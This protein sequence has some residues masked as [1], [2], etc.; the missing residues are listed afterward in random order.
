V[1]GTVSN[2]CTGTISC[3][4]CSPGN[5]CR[6]G[7]CCLTCPPVLEEGD[8]CGTG[9]SSCGNCTAC[10]TNSTCNNGRCRCKADYYE[11]GG[12]CIPTSNDCQ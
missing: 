3:G 11:C 1:C 12:Q 4:T 6:S 7:Q 2:G 5:T 9:F 10:P 8:L